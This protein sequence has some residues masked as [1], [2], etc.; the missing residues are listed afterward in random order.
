VLELA[1]QDQGHAR[2]AVP[3]HPCPIDVVPTI[4]EAVRVQAPLIFNPNDA[5]AAGQAVAKLRQNIGQ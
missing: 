4:L 3:V 1:E 2:T 5:K